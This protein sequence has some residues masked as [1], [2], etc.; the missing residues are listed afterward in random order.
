MFADAFDVAVEGI[1]TSPENEPD[2]TFFAIAYKFGK[3][4]FGNYLE[5]VGFFVDSPALVENHVFDAVLTGEVD[6]S[7]ISVVVDSGLEIDTVEIE[8]VPPFPC[9]FTG[10]YP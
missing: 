7:F 4:D 9:H 6:I 1:V 10:F 2:V 8:G 3:V 5:Q